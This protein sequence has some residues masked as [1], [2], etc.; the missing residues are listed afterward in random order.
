MAPYWCSGSG[1]LR[2]KWR[3]FSPA[4]TDNHPSETYPRLRTC[5]ET[6]QAPCK[7]IRPQVQVAEDQREFFMC[8]RS[9]VF[10]FGSACFHS[11]PDSADLCHRAVTPKAL[12]TELVFSQK[13][14]ETMK[15]GSAISVLGW[16]LFDVFDYDRLYRILLPI[17][18]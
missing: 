16:H 6:R 8:P 11:V 17:Q 12:M 10:V 7:G 14:L 5:T 18:L 9:R 4:P 13:C 3:C 1:Q 15:S 2:L